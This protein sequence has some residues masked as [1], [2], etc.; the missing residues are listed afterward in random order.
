[1]EL[2]WEADGQAGVGGEDGGVGFRLAGGF[3]EVG[4]GGIGVNVGLHPHAVG[5]IGDDEGGEL[6]R[7]EEAD[8]AVLEV[9]GKV[10]GGG[11][12]AARFDGFE[13]AI[14]PKN[15]VGAHGGSFGVEGLEIGIE[16]GGGEVGVFKEAP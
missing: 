6:R 4:E 12:S 13:V 14:A 7:A 10:G 1:M 3:K 2:A 16:G 11:G 8:V 5:G 9:D 15:R